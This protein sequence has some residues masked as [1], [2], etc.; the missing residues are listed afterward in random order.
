MDQENERYG[1]NV[2]RR[3]L[4]GERYEE[5]VMNKLWGLIYHSDDGVAPVFFKLSEVFSG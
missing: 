3:T 4:R 2:I 1:E 5:S